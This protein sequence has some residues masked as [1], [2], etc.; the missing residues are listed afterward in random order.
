MHDQVPSWTH[1]GA[2]LFTI[3]RT[4]SP[5]TEGGR[6]YHL[7]G[8]LRI[9]RSLLPPVLRDAVTAH[10]LER[11]KREAERLI[12]ENGLLGFGMAGVRAL[13]KGV[14]ILTSGGRMDGPADTG[15]VRIDVWICDEKGRPD[16]RG[17]GYV[18]LSPPPLT[19]RVVAVVRRVLPPTA[20]G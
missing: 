1:D 5:R 10:A 17:D 4:M 19:G 2:L 7:T 8:E 12:D 13:E 20:T 6:A 11:L 9:P 15:F 16:R 18:R 3:D 14:R